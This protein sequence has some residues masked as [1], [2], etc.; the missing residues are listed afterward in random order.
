MNLALRLED[1]LCKL[2][3]YTYIDIEKFYNRDNDKYFEVLNNVIVKGEMTL[4]EK[5]ILDEL[6]N[7]L[8]SFIQFETNYNCNIGMF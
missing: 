8:D 6:W 2:Y 7:E 1:V 4:D 5:E 3:D